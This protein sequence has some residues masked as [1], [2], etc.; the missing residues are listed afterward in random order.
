MSYHFIQIL[1][2]YYIC[3]YIYVCTLCHYIYYINIQL[4]Y[5]FQRID[6]E[7]CDYAIILVNCTAYVR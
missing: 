4:Y 1:L 6:G 5:K 7:Y 3:I 2:L